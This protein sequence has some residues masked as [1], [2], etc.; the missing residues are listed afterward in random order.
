MLKKIFKK[1]KPLIIATI[2]VAG[3]ILLLTGIIHTKDLILEMREGEI[4]WISP[5]NKITCELKLNGSLYISGEGEIPD[6]KKAY[7][8]RLHEKYD[9]D[10]IDDYFDAVF[11]AVN[12]NCKTEQ[13]YNKASLYAYIIMYVLGFETEDFEI[14]NG[15]ES[16]YISEEEA[17]F[18]LQKAM[19]IRPWENVSEKIKKIVIE[20]GITGIGSFNFYN[21]PELE[22]VLIGKD[23]KKI[24]VGAFLNESPIDLKIE[25]NGN[26]TIDDN[27]LIT[28]D[29]K[30]LLYFFGD[31]LSYTVPEKIEVIEKY[32]FMGSE[33]KKVELNSGLK[34][35]GNSAFKK[36]RKITS[37]TVPESVTYIGSSAF[38]NCD[39]LLNITLPKKITKINSWTFKYCSSLIYISVPVSVESIGDAAFEGCYSLKEIKIPSK[40]KSIGNWAFKNCSGLV[41]VTFSEGIETIGNYS[42]KECDSLESITIP[43]GCKKLGEGAF[44]WCDELRDVTLPGGIT[45]GNMAFGFCDVLESIEYNGTVEE[46][47][48]LNGKEHIIDRKASVVCTDGEWKE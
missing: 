43:N 5:D 38:E 41:N 32:A 3:T 17:K 9:E 15:F 27:A 35:I 14:E 24:G 21:L 33:L 22:K 6:Y 18:E 10:E 39:S 45:C 2:V 23:V 46:W 29:G 26:F 44:K 40:I 4:I 28:N 42:F 31:D 20:D 30:T 7:V 16:V 47:E 11:S 36:C 13:G 37:I 19:G 8:D 25:D 12:D 34:E 1:C 48:S